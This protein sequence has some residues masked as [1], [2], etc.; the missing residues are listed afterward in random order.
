MA[1][2]QEGGRHVPLPPDIFPTH[3]ATGIN[4]K[5]I[6]S[7]VIKSNKTTDQNRSSNIKLFQLFPTLS[8][9]DVIAHQKSGG[10]LRELLRWKC[11]PHSNKILHYSGVLSKHIVPYIELPA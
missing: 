6:A 8:R 4:V 11:F 2:L 7:T 1:T 5:N 3:V 9:R 10:Y